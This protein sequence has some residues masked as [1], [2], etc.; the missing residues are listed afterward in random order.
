MLSTGCFLQCSF[1]RALFLPTYWAHLG[2]CIA[3]L[4][5]IKH[6]ASDYFSILLWGF[7]LRFDLTIGW[8]RMATH[9]L[10]LATHDNLKTLFIHL[11]SPLFAIP[12]PPPN[13]GWNIRTSVIIHCC[14]WLAICYSQSVFK[15][16]IL[17]LAQQFLCCLLL[18]PSILSWSMFFHFRLQCYW[19]CTSFVDHVKG[20]SR[21]H[22]CLNLCKNFSALWIK[23]LFPLSWIYSFSRLL[24]HQMWWFILFLPN[25]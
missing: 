13:L 10:I 4:L 1:P 21:T 24:L 25:W 23:C 9:F 7:L 18:I 15:L 16:C 5:Y 20:R 3:M 17:S 6:L 19:I 22:C 12:S 8:A 14:S 11:E 2:Q